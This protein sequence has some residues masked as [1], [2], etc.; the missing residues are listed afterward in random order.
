MGRP[1]ADLTGPMVFVQGRLALGRSTASA[2]GLTAALLSLATGICDTPS[3]LPVPLV[4]TFSSLSKVILNYPF[5]IGSF[6]LFY[7]I[8]FMLIV[9]YFFIEFIGVTLVNKIA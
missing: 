9:F 4:D 7:F 2:P 8:I 6:I 3:L 1:G 5:P